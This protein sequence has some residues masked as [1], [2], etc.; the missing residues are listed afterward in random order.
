MNSPIRGLRNNNP[1]NI[2]K[3]ANLWVGRCDG[4]DP[5]FESFVSLEYG[6][7]AGLKLLLNY[8]R[9]GYLTPALIINRFA[10]RSENSTQ[11]YID[12][13]CRNARGNAYIQPDVPFTDLH[14]FLFFC[15]RIIKYENG[16]NGNQME[17]YGFTYT[18]LEEII[19]TFNLNSDKVL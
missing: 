3:G 9:K 7:R 2:K 10:P 19:N 14:Q 1:F 18:R 8:V 11:S 12:F 5:S 4:N 13:V 16:L 6:L 17:N 15:L